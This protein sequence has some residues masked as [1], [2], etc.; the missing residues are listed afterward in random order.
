[1][2][3]MC[4]HADICTWKVCNH[5]VPHDHQLGCDALCGKN[6]SIAKC[7]EYQPFGEVDININTDMH[8]R[9]RTCTKK[10]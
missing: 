3:M 8:G 4:D 7:F 6:D 1:M 10:Q 9:T 5:K 2:L